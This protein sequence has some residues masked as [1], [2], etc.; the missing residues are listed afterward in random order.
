MHGASLA[1]N[2]VSYFVRDSTKMTDYKSIHFEKWIVICHNSIPITGR[3][4]LK[5]LVSYFLQRLPI[6]G[7]NNRTKQNRNIKPFL[8]GFFNRKS[9]VVVFNFFFYAIPAFY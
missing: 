7:F 1:S 3:A 8:C 4:A 6:F 5:I 2:A 9:D